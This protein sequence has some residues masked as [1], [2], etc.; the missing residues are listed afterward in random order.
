MNERDSVLEF[1]I[2]GCQVKLAG[3]SDN[4]IEAQDII[5]L[6]EKE[7]SSIKAHMPDISDHQL[8]VLT[9]LKIAREKLTGETEFKGNLSQ[10]KMGLNEALGHIEQVTASS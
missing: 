8:A 7:A 2:L 10:L 5:N 1:N 9:S 3:D 4:N 6:V